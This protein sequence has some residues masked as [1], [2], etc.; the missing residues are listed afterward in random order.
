MQSIAESVGWQYNHGMKTLIVV[1]VAIG[2]GMAG[3][4]YFATAC[5]D[6]AESQR[7]RAV[8]AEQQAKQALEKSKAERP[9]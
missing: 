3:Y 6:A 8:Q 1:V 4:W 2:F 5:R 7:V 9:K